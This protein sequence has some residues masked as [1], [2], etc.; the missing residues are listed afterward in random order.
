[1]AE[2]LYGRL[3]TYELLFVIY[4]GRH[5]AQIINGAKSMNVYSTISNVRKKRLVKAHSHKQTF[6]VCF[7]IL[8]RAQAGTEKCINY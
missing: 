6:I 5:P 7:H 2:K 4:Y 8:E 3:S 1:M